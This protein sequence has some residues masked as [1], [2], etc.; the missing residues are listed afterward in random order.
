MRAFYATFN[1]Q[2]KPLPMTKQDFN[3]KTAQ[4]KK[5]LKDIRKLANLRIYQGSK[6]HILDQCNIINSCLK[7]INE[8]FC[9]LAI[10]AL[11]FALKVCK[12]TI[13]LLLKIRGKVKIKFKELV[14]ARDNSEGFDRC[15]LNVRV[16]EVYNLLRPFIKNR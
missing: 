3:K 10:S 11:E 8:G 1:N 12:S 2:L 9:D 15:Q 5:Q 7:K 4:V 16:E 6:I 13:D 14:K